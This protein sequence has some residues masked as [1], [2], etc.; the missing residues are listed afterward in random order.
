LSGELAGSKL[1]PMHQ[2]VHIGLEIADPGTR[3]VNYQLTVVAPAVS[4]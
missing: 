3:A 2:P 1:M 4:Q